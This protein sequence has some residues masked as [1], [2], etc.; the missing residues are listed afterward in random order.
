VGR[1]SA[2]ERWKNNQQTNHYWLSPN[3]LESSSIGSY[4]RQLG[5]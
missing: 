5:A 3:Q 1:D 4:S 2:N